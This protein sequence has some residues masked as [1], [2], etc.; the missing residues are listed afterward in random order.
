MQNKET[1]AALVGDC[2]FENWNIHLA[3]DGDRPYVQVRFL[4]KDEFS[5]RVEMQHGRKWMLSYHM[6]DSE[7]VQ[8]VF[9]AVER[10]MMHEVKEKFKFRGRRIYNPHQSVHALWE[11]AG[12]KANIEVRDNRNE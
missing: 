5:D 11:L 3:Y 2:Q 6:C 9:A 1:L 4:E 7:V 10:A 8:T 12:K